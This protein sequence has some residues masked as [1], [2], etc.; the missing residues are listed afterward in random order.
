MRPQRKVFNGVNAATTSATEAAFAGISGFAAAAAAAA[1]TVKVGAVL[2][3][4][5]Q[6]GQTSWRDRAQLRMTLFTS[7]DGWDSSVG[8]L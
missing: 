2:R 4:R 5:P 6:Q 7:R 8:W 3:A 1:A